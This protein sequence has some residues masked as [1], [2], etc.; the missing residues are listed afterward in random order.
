M[1]SL[2]SREQALVYAL[3]SA[4]VLR[5]VA[6]TC[7]S[8]AASTCGCGRSPPTARPGAA[9]AGAFRWGG[10]ADNVAF[11]ADFSTAFCD[12]RWAKSARRRLRNR[13]AAT[14][15]HNYRAGRAVSWVPLNFSSLSTAKSAKHDI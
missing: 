6:R 3:S 7:S 4:A 2:G 8:G 14:N 15:L 1:G 10:C 9:E 12:A 11:G 13:R 5:A